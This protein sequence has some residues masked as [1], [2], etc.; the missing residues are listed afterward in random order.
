[1]T[2]LTGT[3]LA[4]DPKL[5]RCQKINQLLDGMGYRERIAAVQMECRGKAT[6]MSPE[7]I[8]ANRPAMLMGI[9][10]G[11]PSWT[12]VNKAYDDFIEEACGSE[13]LL[14]LVLSGYRYAW[15]ARVPEGELEAV[16]A[17]LRQKGPEGIQEHATFVSKRV[18]DVLMPLLVRMAALAEKNYQARIK[19]I[20][21]GEALEIAEGDMCEAPGGGLKPL[22][23][24]LIEQPR[25]RPKKG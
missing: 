12:Q 5:P 17:A 20:V 11:T 10:K 8:A 21:G 14:Y 23:E 24:R 7:S 18:N 13:E 2:C 4:C 22:S 16:L 19:G 6:R 15:D 9:E 3:A 25:L 1:M